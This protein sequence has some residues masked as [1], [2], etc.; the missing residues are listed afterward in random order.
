MAEEQELKI[1]VT[2]ED[3]ASASLVKLNE[4]MRQLGG[5]ATA[6]L[7]KMGRSAKETARSAKELH[8]ELGALA[9]RAGLVGGVV[10]GITAELTKMG[11]ELVGRITDLQGLSRETVAL[12]RAAASMGTS[13][14]QL[15]S[16]INTIRRFGISAAEA[17]RGLAV[18]HERLGDLQRINSST[19]Q[20]LATDFGAGVDAVTKLAD[21]LRRLKPE[22]AYT[23]VREFI[24]AE[25]DRITK[26][27]GPQA[28]AREASRIS[29]LFAGA[30]WLA[31]VKTNLATVSA[32][33][34]E[35]YE[36]RRA[37]M[38]EFMA[39]SVTTS[40]EMD[41]VAKS[42]G[43][44]AALMVTP[45]MQRLEQVVT[46][47][48]K[49]SEYGETQFRKT[50]QTLQTLTP[51]AIPAPF[52][53]LG[54][55]FNM[56]DIFGWTQGDKKTPGATAPQHFGAG[57]GMPFG[58]N[59]PEEGRSSI[60]DLSGGYSQNI[61]DRRNEVQT[62]D[63]N[64][65]QLTDLTG[66]VRRLTDALMFIEPGG[67]LGP[68]STRMGGLRAGL[69]GG[70]GYGGAGGPMGALP[71]LGA[72]GGGGAGAGPGGATPA[73]MPGSV[74][75]QG[76]PTGGGGGGFTPVSDLATAAGAAPA[77]AGGNIDTAAIGKETDDA[78]LMRR[79]A[80]M[81]RGEIG[82]NASVEDQM[83]QLETARNRAL[84]RGHSVEQALWGTAEHGQ[85]G[86]YPP[87]T[88]SR[89]TG[90]LEAF[91]KNVW[92]PVMK[93]GSNV[94]ER[95]LGSPGEGKMW[96]GNASSDLA[97][98]QKSKLQHA[99][100]AGE[101]YFTE[102]PFRRPVPYRSD[103]M[104]TASAVSSLRTAPT[105][106]LNLEG[107]TGP[108]AMAP[109]IN[110]AAGGGSD[111]DRMVDDYLWS[112]YEKSE[113]KDSS[114]DFTWKDPAAA[115]RLGMSTQDYVIGGM[116]REL[117]N[118]LYTQF[119]QTEAEGGK[120]QLLSGFRD[121]YRQQIASGFKARTGH[122]RHG[123][124]QATGGYGLGEA[125]DVD[126]MT[127][128]RIARAS[129]PLSR[130]MPGN[131]PL[132]VQVKGRQGLTSGRSVAPAA[133]IT[134]LATKPS[135]S[136]VDASMLDKSSVTVNG[137]GKIDVTVKASG[138]SSKQSELYKPVPI[139]HQKQME[140]AAPT[141]PESTNQEE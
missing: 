87:S 43:S 112:V 20:T 137:S 94:A 111:H 134:T 65:Q 7:D 41:K 37:H 14:A 81:V 28:G 120:P 113:H 90:D 16:N 73:T 80:M 85:K 122:S 51:R 19:F 11:L 139:Q 108:T 88:F 50:P 104:Q 6:G 135:G 131:D 58:F 22:E 35:L 109:T 79:A 30:P 117:K 39:S 74:A 40:I 77:A 68:M 141:P 133:K 132:H 83:I 63:D 52:N 27:A 10:G 38:Q 123:G 89:G 106:D 49:I 62:L 138:S 44:I 127:A 59:I 70:S 125:A 21:D 48:A 66:E 3:Q 102:G 4:D 2:L 15:E 26:V 92:D 33:E 32:W 53:P 47:L 57:G 119:K 56:L 46:G 114:G 99:T 86:Y 140:P 69:G 76:Y 61:E 64:T 91:K 107:F 31:D 36:K 136:D 9:T 25:R 96:T 100:N 13:S 23:R 126:A 24:E 130:P 129:G 116:S 5:S 115:K 45:A 98:R 105:S 121:D 67:A 97:E 72:G 124:S 8:G 34:E 95:K 101:T 128:D 55:I 118:N 71:G 17:E 103:P 93:G 84:V 82:P 54:G 110:R 78:V 29:M 18:F 60:S 12:G 75:S 42:F 1:V